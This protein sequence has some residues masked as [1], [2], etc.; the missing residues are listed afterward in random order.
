MGE[1]TVSINGT[2]YQMS[3]YWPVVDLT[4]QKAITQMKNQ[5]G[6][7]VNLDHILITGGGATILERVFLRSYPEL[8]KI[9]IVDQEPVYSNVKGFLHISKIVSMHAK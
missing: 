2:E 7:F 4:L 1:S 3:N 5:V 6:T 8:A 9:T